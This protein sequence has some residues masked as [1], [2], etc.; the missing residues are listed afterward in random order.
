MML[1]GGG[2]I[3]GGI[4]STECENCVLVQK[5]GMTVVNPDYRLAPE[6]P[7]PAGVLDCW[8]VVKWVCSIL[9]W[10]VLLVRA[11]DE[12]LPKQR[13]RSTPKS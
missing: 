10:D 5:F 13:P 9:H 8:D 11:A 4:Q 12:C 2:W 6:H 3:M 1:H 7:F